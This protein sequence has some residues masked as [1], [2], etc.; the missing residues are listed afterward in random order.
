MII[1]HILLK[2]AFPGND[3]ETIMDQFVLGNDIIVA[4]VTEKGARSRKVI[5]PDGK[6][7]AEDGKTYK[8]GIP[9]Q[10]SVPL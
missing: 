8:G 7:K 10:I 9:L 6:W 3:Y 5:L 1:P 2:L 4:P